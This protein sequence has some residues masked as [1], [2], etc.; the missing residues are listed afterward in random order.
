MGTRAK[1][2]PP[3]SASAQRAQC[4]AALSKAGVSKN[5]HT[6]TPFFFFCCVLVKSLPKGKNPLSDHVA[7]VQTK[8]NPKELGGVISRD[9]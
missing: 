6:Y 1:P 5:A 8:A 2:A 9:G 7:W 4:S 3:S